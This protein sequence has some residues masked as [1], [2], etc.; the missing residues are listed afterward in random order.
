MINSHSIAYVYLQTLNFLQPMAYPKISHAKASTCVSTKMSSRE[1]GKKYL[2][3]E[4]TPDVYCRVL[5]QIT[6]LQGEMAAFPG[7]VLVRSK[8]TGQIVGSIGV[9]GAAGA[10]DEYCAWR[11]VHECTEADELVTEPEQHSCST[12]K[13]QDL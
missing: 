5:N 4:G 6:T 9:S 8:A 1:Y 3:S 12:K 7:G 10:E 11:A 2:H 13:D